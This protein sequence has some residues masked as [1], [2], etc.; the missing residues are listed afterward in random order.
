MRLN[1][2]VRDELIPMWTQLRSLP[3]QRC[4]LQWLSV[5]K[6]QPHPISLS[7][8]GVLLRRTRTCELRM[9]LELPLPKNRRLPSRTYGTTHNRSRP[10]G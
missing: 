2:A 9:L 4:Q 7:N 5:L 10:F 3:Q 8:T 1:N 6:R